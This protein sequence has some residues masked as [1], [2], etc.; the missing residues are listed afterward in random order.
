L[1][2]L[3]DRATGWLHEVVGD[4][5]HAFGDRDRYML[6]PQQVFAVRDRRNSLSLTNEAEGS[7]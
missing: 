5:Q 2:R 7:N 4:V 3:I 1:S 6:L